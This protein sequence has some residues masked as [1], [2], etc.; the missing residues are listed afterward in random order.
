MMQ[1]INILSLFLAFS[2]IYNQDRAHNMLAIMLDPC[3]KNMKIIQDFV[4][5]A[6][7]TQIVTNY[8]INI[9]CLLLL[10]VFFHL[11]PIKVVE[12]D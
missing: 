5:N 6:H 2:Y 7:A 8:D 9:V 3:F 12:I 10:H 1:V 4:G 11:N